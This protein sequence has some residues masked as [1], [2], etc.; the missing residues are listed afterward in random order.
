MEEPE[1]AEPEV[2]IQ[3]PDEPRPVEDLPPPLDD[4]LGLDAEGVA[5][6]DAFGLKAKQGGRS[7]LSLADGS[8][9]DPRWAAYASA[10]ESRLQEYLSG[11]ESLE[12][13]AYRVELRLWIDGDG[14]VT[15]CD[16]IRGTGR[17]ALDEEIR[18]S[19]LQGCRIPEAQPRGLPQPVRL[20]IDSR[21]AG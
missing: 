4:A 18:T 14:R 1:A 15:H 16:F 19:L 6:S 20:R 10:L 21:A 3:E 2:E 12:G 11:V 9:M 7:L 17:P 8:G 5:G 13:Q